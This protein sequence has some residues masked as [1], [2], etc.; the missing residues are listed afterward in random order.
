MTYSGY[1]HHVRS[2]SAPA[3]LTS[4]EEELE[5]IKQTEVNVANIGSCFEIQTSF[6]H[7]AMLLQVRQTSV[8]ARHQTLQGL[9]F[10]MQEQAVDKLVELQQGI[11]TYVQLVSH[12]R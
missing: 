7:S 3:P 5:M 6:K 9:A 11:I 8:D 2:N 4:R 12:L 10:P 1:Q